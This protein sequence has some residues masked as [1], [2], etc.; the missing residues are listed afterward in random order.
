MRRAEAAARAGG[1]ALEDGAVREDG[2][3]MTRAPAVLF[4][5]EAQAEGA[6]EPPAV[7]EPG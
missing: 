6:V 5:G 3:V 2:R 4:G 7:F 1:A